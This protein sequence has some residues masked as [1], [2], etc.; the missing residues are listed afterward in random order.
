MLGCS[1]VFSELFI[2]V[3]IVG[4]LVLLNTG[5]ISF[6]SRLKHLALG[7]KPYVYVT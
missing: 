7:F 2:N 4:D 5:S 3:C 1:T 6:D